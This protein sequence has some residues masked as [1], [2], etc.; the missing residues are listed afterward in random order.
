MY[1]L[2]YGEWGEIEAPHFSELSDEEYD[3]PIYLSIY[4]NTNVFKAK[5]GDS[6]DVKV[7]DKY[8]TFQVA[9]FYEGI[10]S[11]SMGSTSF[12]S[13]ISKSSQESKLPFF[14]FCKEKTP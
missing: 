9:G 3:N 10:F 11:N 7:D 8:Y 2:P 4:M 12:L 6:L 1:I 5:L 14:S 13:P